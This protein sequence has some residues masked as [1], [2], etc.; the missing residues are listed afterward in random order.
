MTIF[1]T[2]PEKERGD[3]GPEPLHQWFNFRC[4]N[5]TGFFI[6]PL[7]VVWGPGVSARLH[8][9]ASPWIRASDWRV[10]PADGVNPNTF[11][12]MRATAKEPGRLE[13][14]GMPFR[15]PKGYLHLPAYPARGAVWCEKC[16][17]AIDHL[18]SE[19]PGLNSLLDGR[20][21]NNWQPRVRAYLTVRDE[22]EDTTEVARRLGT[23]PAGN[24][25]SP[26]TP[27]TDDE[28]GKVENPERIDEA[29]DN[30]ADPEQIDRDQGDPVGRIVPGLLG[31]QD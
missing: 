12:G 13:W 31:P 26:T 9:A 19:L 14:Y 1:R 16:L 17:A 3:L 10:A 21:P 24:H 4:I 8:L 18:M 7:G 30:E 29:D 22:Y 28:L 15:L 20:I 5:G 2:D 25:A 23:E 11:C 27:K 6:P